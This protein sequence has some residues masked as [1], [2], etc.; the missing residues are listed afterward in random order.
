MKTFNTTIIPYGREK[1]FNDLFRHKP[2]IL[3][4]FDKE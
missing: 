4:N 3:N 2:D 1:P